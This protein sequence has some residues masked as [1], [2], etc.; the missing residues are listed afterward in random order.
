MTQIAISNVLKP[1]LIAIW[2]LHAVFSGRS[3]ANAFNLRRKLD[4]YASVAVKMILTG[5]IVGTLPQVYQLVS[6]WITTTA[7]TATATGFISMLFGWYSRN[8]GNES[9]GK[10]GWLLR[11]GLVVLLYGI[12][13][14]GYDFAQ[15]PWEE[16]LRPLATGIQEL[17]AFGSIDG[18]AL[19]LVLASLFLSVLIGTFGN[20]NHVSMHRFYR[21][22]LLEAY[23]VS[24]NGDSFDQHAAANNFYLRDIV[25][26]T[27]P[28]H[29]INVA[30]NTI[31]SKDA[32][33]CIRGGDNFIFSPLYC[34]SDATGYAANARRVCEGKIIPGY[35]GGS[36]DLATAFTIS[37]AAVDPNT[38][39][40][41]SRPLAFLMSLLNVRLGYW[42]RNP[43]KPALLKNFSRPRWHFDLLYE[44][45]GIKLNEHHRHVHLSDGGH[46]ENLAAYELIRRQC[47]YV[48]VS[49]GAAD[50]DSI[51]TDLAK[52]IEL[53]RVDF[54]AAV[55]IDVTALQSQ[56]DQRLSKRPYVVGNIYYKDGTQ[57][58]FIYIKSCMV[59]EL[60]DDIYSYRRENKLFPHEPTSDQFFT[61]VQFEAYRELGFQLGRQIFAQTREGEVR[62]RSISEI[63]TLT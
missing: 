1:I 19:S 9:S 34:G 52:L 42:I 13:L 26:T 62:N 58:H 36:M 55:V 40:T 3:F 32:K 45:L 17:A 60:N 10:S 47:R 50:P 27:A 25:Q 29:I 53:V 37:G 22:R 24:P 41:R 30:M 51:F 20:I 16:Y 8:T 63:C 21:D 49:D 33:L 44:M 18:W 11:I 2:I 31:A 39:V 48:I 15:R 46:F 59:S 56:S 4:C 38:G 54:G 61:E 14:A 28:Y 5:F 43:S 7:S 23:L 35:L 57:G 6:A 12:L